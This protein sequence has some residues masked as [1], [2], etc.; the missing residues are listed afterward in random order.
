MSLQ[1]VAIVAYM[2]GRRAYL[3]RI[4]GK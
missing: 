1:L 3:R 2:A 4:E